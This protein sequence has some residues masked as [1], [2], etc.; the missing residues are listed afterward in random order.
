MTWNYDTADST[1]VIL[2]LTYKIWDYD[3]ADST[4]VIPGVPR[5]SYPFAQFRSP[6]CFY[7]G[8]VFILSAD[9]PVLGI[10]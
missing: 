5:F 6:A 9:P 4:L 8:P 3:T 2:I 7:L 10:L 1:K